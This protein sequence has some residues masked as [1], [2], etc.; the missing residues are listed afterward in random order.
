MK[1]AKRMT[2][3]VDIVLEIKDIYDTVTTTIFIVVIIA[4]A[5]GKCE[6][7]EFGSE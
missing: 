3:N 6:Q 1:H 2:K 7:G 5:A 4:M